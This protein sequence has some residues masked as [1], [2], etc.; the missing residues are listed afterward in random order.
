MPRKPRPPTRPSKNWQVNLGGTTIRIED[1]TGAALVAALDS[2]ADLRIAV[3]R[4][5]PYLYDGDRGYERDYLTRY[6]QS[7]GAI[8]VGAFDGDRLAGAA[9]AA[10]MADHAA[11]FAAPFRAR[12]MDIGRIYYFGES[13]LL[14]DWRGRGIGHAFF[15]RREARA[16]ELGFAMTS[17]CAVVRPPDHPARPAD[18][19]PLDSFWRARGYAP[20]DG[21][22]GEFHWK[23]LGDAAETSHPM[24]FWIKSLTD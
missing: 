6:A 9:T 20:A 16:C 18:Y 23:D 22:T 19:S 15:D 2:L 3:F 7:P 11:E 13:V 8:V 14:P 12:G 24:Q 10:P 4:A 17:F 21:L 1:L 5:F